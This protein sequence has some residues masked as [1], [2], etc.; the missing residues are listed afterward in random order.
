MKDSDKY[1]YLMKIKSNW[2]DWMWPFSRLMWALFK[3]W[4]KYKKSIFERYTKDDGVFHI[5]NELNN[6]WLIKEN[7]SSN[8]LRNRFSLTSQ[9]E[10][11]VNSYDN[12]STAKL[13]NYLW[14]YPNIWKLFY[15]LLG[16]SIWL[17]THLLK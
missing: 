7:L 4:D 2:I 16:L 9:W 13:D 15:F 8:D 17:I 11:F 3:L 5:I 6:Q 10:Y 14:K 12:S 1:K